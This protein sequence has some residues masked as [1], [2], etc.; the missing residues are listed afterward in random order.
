MDPQDREKLN[1]FDVLLS[2]DGCSDY[3]HQMVLENVALIARRRDA[4]GVALAE[5]FESDEAVLDILDWLKGGEYYDEEKGKWIEW[6]SKTEFHYRSAL[7]KFGKVLNDGTL[8]EPMEIIYGGDKSKPSESAPKK[9]E[10]LLWHEDVVPL[11]KACQ[12]DRDRALIVVAWDSGARPFEIRDLTYGDVSPDG[13]FFQI[14]IGGKNTP[15]RDPRLVIAAPFLKMWLEQSH[16]AND[17]EGGFTRETPIWTQLAENKKLANDSFGRII[18]R[19]VA[20]RVD[21]NKP[22]NLRQFRKSRSSILASREEIGR[23]DLEERQGW[24]TGS[25]IVNAYINRFGSG[26]D[27]KISKSDGLAESDLPDSDHEELPD[28]APVKCPNCSRWTPGYPDECIW[29]STRFNTDAA[30]EAEHRD[31][32]SPVKDQA[33]RD[34]I[35]LVTNGEL[36]EENIETARQLAEVVRQHPEILD[37]GDSLQELMER[38]NVKENGSGESDD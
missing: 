32:E 36:T 2:H 24:K 16:P 23:G 8:P 18:P 12:N 20:T 37:F 22:T 17:E 25:D 9:R 29:C 26:T 28:P 4:H 13:D 35:D 30:K 38:H 1:E 5:L 11:L 15:Q 31:V 33:R 27:D 14:T 6:A 34:L 19:K 7:R 21:I 10:I 3:W